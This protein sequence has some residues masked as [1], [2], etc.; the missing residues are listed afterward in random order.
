MK[1]ME[2]TEK[3][4]VLV[5]KLE[6]MDFVGRTA[7]FLPS[8][9][10][11]QRI[12]NV[13]NYTHQDLQTTIVGVA[14]GVGM[15]I[16]EQYAIECGV[17]TAEAVPALREYIRQRSTEIAAER[18]VA[19]AAAGGVGSMSIGVPGSAPDDSPKVN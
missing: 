10:D 17:L 4:K 5:E 18:E 7:G 8:E 6:Q 12:V 11:L 9:L 16:Y 2:E 19:F 13:S 1:E 3:E 15:D 14:V